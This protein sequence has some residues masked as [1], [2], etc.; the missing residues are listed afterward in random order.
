MLQI[1]ILGQF[2]IRLD[3]ERITIT[4]RVGQSLFAYLALTAGTPHRR[5]KLS[6]IF[7]AD[8]SDEI[9]RKYLRQ[10]LW[11][12]RKALSSQQSDGE[13]YL[14][15]DE[16]TIAFNRAPDIGWML[17]SSNGPIWISNL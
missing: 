7:W 3:R 15:A 8:T 10:E 4:S 12:I 16:F 2:D 9:A 14:V 5:E 11:R 13:E 17:P 6:G 1:R